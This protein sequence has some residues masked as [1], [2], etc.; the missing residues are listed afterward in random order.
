[1][2]TP[3]AEVQFWGLTDQTRPNKFLF[4]LN[5]AKNTMNS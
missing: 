5:N 4:S 3:K 1:M 2:L